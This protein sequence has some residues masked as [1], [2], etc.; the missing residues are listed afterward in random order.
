MEDFESRRMKNALKASRYY[1]ENNYDQS[2][3]AKEMGLSRPTVSRLLQ[4]A[5]DNGYV[6]IKIIDPFSNVGSLEKQLKE[7]YSLKK[8]IV[9]NTPSNEYQ[10]II[11]NIGKAGAKYLE[12]IVK[13][14]DSI[15][16]SWGRTLSEVAKNL[17]PNNN[18]QEN[19]KIVQIKGGVAHSKMSNFA[20]EVISKFSDSFHTVSEILPLPIIFDTV[21]TSELVQRDTQTK[22]IMNEVLQTNIVVF[23]VGTVRDD[24]MM[25]NLG[26]LSDNEISSLK[27]DAVGDIS[28]RFINSNGEIASKEINDR[29]IGISLDNLKHK[30]HSILIAGGEHKVA[31]IKAALAGGFVTDL[32]TDN[33]TALALL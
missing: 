13:D 21:E 14:N 20:L 30:E 26:Y 27:E 25:F 19:V 29:T 24:N 16:V 4:Y 9:T 3:I 8:V 22:T 6:Q 28:S 2:R 18:P 5:K 31:P 17:S 33:F 11:Q 23:T 1:Y 7:K 12:S 10:T 32:I 15:G